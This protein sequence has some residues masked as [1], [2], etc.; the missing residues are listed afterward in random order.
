MAAETVNEDIYTIRVITLLADIGKPCLLQAL[1][2]KV[3]KEIIH[4]FLQASENRKIIDQLLIKKVITEEQFDQL[5]AEKINPDKFDIGLTY[6]ILRYIVAPEPKK[7]WNIHPE[8]DD[9]SI[10]ACLL[11]I[12]KLRNRIYDPNTKIDDEEFEEIWEELGENIKQIVSK[13]QGEAACTAVRKTIRNL[14]KETEDSLKKNL[15]KNV[16]ELFKWSIADFS[17]LFKAVGS[18]QVY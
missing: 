15:K 5:F 16:E 13:T 17:S 18:C 10:G 9:N 14:K 2:H 6:A 4:Q 8:D 11:R 1:L 7:G 3:P 12:Q